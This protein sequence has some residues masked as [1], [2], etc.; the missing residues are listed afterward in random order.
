M[1][2]NEMLWD[3]V[4]NEWNKHMGGVPVAAPAAKVADVAQEDVPDFEEPK[5]PKSSDEDLTDEDL[6]KELRDMS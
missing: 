6:M 4:E 1:L 3:I 2:K 5:A